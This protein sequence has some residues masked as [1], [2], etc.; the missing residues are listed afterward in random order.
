TIYDSGNY[1][2]LLDHALELSAYD[3]LLQQRD[4]RRKEGELV[5]VG[6][7]TFVEMTGQGSETGRVL[8]H[9]D[10]RVTA[11]TGSHSQGQGHKTVFPQIV[12]SELGVPYSAIQLVQADTHRVPDGTGT[13]GSRSTVAGG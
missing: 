7:A 9:P 13:F 6:L 3:T 8:A 11:F 12:A 4:A 2:A 1:P 10:G 5:G